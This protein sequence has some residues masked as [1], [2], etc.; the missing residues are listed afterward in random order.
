MHRPGSPLHREASGSDGNFFILFAVAACAVAVVLILFRIHRSCSKWWKGGSHLPMTRARG[1]LPRIQANRRP[2]RATRTTR[3]SPKRKSPR[4]SERP[5]GN[6]SAKSK[7]SGASSV[8]MTMTSSPKPPR[9]A[10][11]LLRRRRRRRKRK[12]GPP[13]EEENEAAEDGLAAALDE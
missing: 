8:M 6:V 4:W 3:T 5:A 1:H 7:R 12:R 9:T 11:P 13:P 10:R 2:R